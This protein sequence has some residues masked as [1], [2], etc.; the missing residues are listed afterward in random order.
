M[1]TFSMQGLKK[2]SR[3]W[4]VTFLASLSDG[5]GTDK[6]LP[7]TGSRFSKFVKNRN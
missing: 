7:L 3:L 2:K 4:Q 5:K 6:P 1:S